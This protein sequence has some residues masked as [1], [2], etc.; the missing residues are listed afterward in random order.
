MFATERGIIVAWNL[1]YRI[2]TAMK[3]CWKIFLMMWLVGTQGAHAQAPNLIWIM[4]D[5]LGYGE[6]GCYGQKVIPTPHIDRMA[7][8]GMRFTHYYSGATV[9]APSRCVLMTGLHQGHA[10]VRGNKAA[11]GLTKA[12]VSVATVLQQAGYRTACIGKWGLG[13][14]DGT[15]E[16]L[17]KH[18]GFDRFFGYLNHTHAHNH[19]PDY[20]WRDDAKEKLPNVVVPV[21]AKGGGYATKAV[22][23]ADDLFAD[24]A[25][26]FVSE[27]STK[28][29]FLYWSMVSPHA[30]N[31][32]QTALGDGANVPDYG[33]FADKPWPVQDRGHAAMIAR[34]D[35]YVGRMLEQLQTLGIAQNTLVI[36]TSDNG[37]HK[38]SGHDLTRFQPS[39]PF[40]G[41][42]RSLTDG[43]IRVPFIASWKNHITAGQVVEAPVASIDAT[44]TALK[45][46]GVLAPEPSTK[47][48]AKLDGI[49]LMPLLTGKTTQLP[50]RPL[51]W[52]VGK[53][54]A[55]RLG[56]WKLIRDGKE[57]QLYDLTHDISETRN[58]ATQEPARVQQL[59]ALWDKWNAEQMEPL[60]R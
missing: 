34:L 57:W 1:S 9:C 43:G 26:K 51:F 31:E 47:A 50:E 56:D 13:E 46:A 48:E 40:T 18:Q 10:R 32:R 11:V 42:K 5:D 4:A 8:E 58:L 14:H 44:A 12:D 2:L 37:P 52:R 27:K 20:L 39:G 30:N 21:G 22:A 38:E 3:Q 6:L 16:G 29:F 59:S 19:F 25:L 35:R 60:W 45:F 55:L 36:F 24:E 28:P 7:K 15:E 49:N 41:I 53:K 23:Y 17:P 54:N 33:D